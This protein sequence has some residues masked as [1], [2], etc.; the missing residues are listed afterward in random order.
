MEKQEPPKI[1]V[2]IILNLITNF[3]NVLG[4]CF[5]YLPNMFVKIIFFFQNYVLH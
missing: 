2:N 3:L 1:D 5:G 4:M